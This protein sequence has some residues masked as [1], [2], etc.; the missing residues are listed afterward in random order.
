MH[1]GA[2][3][4]AQCIEKL[5]IALPFVVEVQPS[6]SP[7]P[8]HAHHGLERWQVC[9]ARDADDMVM[10]RHGR[11][12]LESNGADAGGGTAHDISHRGVGSAHG[13]ALE[14]LG[15]YLGAYLASRVGRCSLHRS[16]S[17]HE[18]EQGGRRWRMQ[19]LEQVLER[20]KIHRE[21]RERLV[22]HVTIEAVDQGAQPDGHSTLRL[23]RGGS[24]LGGLGDARRCR[25]GH[26]LVAQDA[27][28]WR[29]GSTAHG[30]RSLGHCCGDVIR[31][32][33]HVCRYGRYERTQ[34]ECWCKVDSS[35]A[36]K[37]HHGLDSR[38]PKC[39]CT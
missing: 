39:R 19:V 29:T 15:A 16:G 36:L 1:C 17:L 23:H 20:P 33:R 21:Q 30:A 2:Q 3:Q 9:A 34:H 32:A 27:R 8:F 10:A 14:P 13:S 35:I 11:A 31:Q 6:K 24:G 22:T 25:R 38:T 26:V 37:P 28:R 4:R 5:L 12:H 18:K 7:Q